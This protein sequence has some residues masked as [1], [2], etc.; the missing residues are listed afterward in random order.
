MDMDKKS[1]AGA[2]IPDDAVANALLQWISLSETQ[3]RSFK[4]LATEIDTASSLVE[5]ST[6]KLASQFK[7]LVGFATEQSQRLDSILA[8][9]SRVLVG[10]Q[11]LDLTDVFDDLQENLSDLV[12]KIVIVD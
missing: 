11:E 4:A 1:N 10:D 8:K 9:G 6:D 7:E 5:V 12:N 2:G 3:R